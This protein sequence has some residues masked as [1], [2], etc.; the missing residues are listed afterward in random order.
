MTTDHIP[1]TPILWGKF[2]NLFSARRAIKKLRAILEDEMLMQ[3]GMDYEVTQTHDTA[4]DTF[5]FTLKFTSFTS[6]FCMWRIKGNGIPELG[7]QIFDLG[8]DYAR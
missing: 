8:F 2:D 3:L 1:D 4:A 7:K 5:E 6:R